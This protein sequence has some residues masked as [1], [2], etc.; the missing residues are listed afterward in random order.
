VNRGAPVPGHE[1]TASAT[2]P[3]AVSAALKF[4]L[5]VGVMSLFADFT[6]EGSRSIVGP[7]LGALGAGALA[8]AVITGLGEFLG[9][10]LR[11]VSGRSA[12]RTRLH[13]PI[14]IGGYILQMTVVPLLALAGSWQVAALLVVLERAGKA[15]RNPPRDAMLSHAAKQMGYGW[16]FAVHEALDQVGALLGPLAV[17][18]VLALKHAD[19]KLA[20]ASLAVPAAIML[21]L[22][23]VARITYPRPQDLEPSGLEVRTAGLPRIFW[24]YLVGAAL[25]GAGFA[26]YPLIA[27]HLQRSSTVGS[28]L[29][30]I[31]YAVAMAISGLGSLAFGRMF[32]RSGIAVLVPLA[33][34]S[35][36]YAPLA[37]FGGFWVAFAGVAIWGLGM[38]VQESVMSAAVAPMVSPDRRSSAYGLFTGVYGTAWFA[39]SVLIGALY[40]V[41]FGYLVA[42]AIAC[43][44]AA[45][46]FILIVHSRRRRQI[47][48]QA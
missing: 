35:A 17:A 36:A 30:P 31:F 19:Y 3:V 13:W 15:T 11:L 45:I 1:E 6:Y 40:E 41:S 28:G 5:M 21:S 27:Y 39:G 8:I 12:D 46:P 33:V 38:G 16:G 32:D 37:F 22:L 2:R 34:V 47:T 26:D 20:F 4:V 9:Y 18:L 43:E 14:A 44:L 23:A 48:G 42:F 7:Y 24:I 25:A 10:G 29:I